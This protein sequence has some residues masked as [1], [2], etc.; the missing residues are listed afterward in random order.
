[1]QP[2][3]GFVTQVNRELLLDEP[4]MG[5]SLDM[6]RSCQQV[7]LRR[8]IPGNEMNCV[9]RSIYGRIAEPAKTAELVR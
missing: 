7:K 2:H 4:V 8:Y 6:G 5:M 1:M 3:Y 9:D